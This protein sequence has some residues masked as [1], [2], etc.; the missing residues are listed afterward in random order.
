MVLP[1]DA[2]HFSRQITAELNDGDLISVNDH[3]DDAFIYAHVPQRNL[4]VQYGPYQSSSA[5]NALIYNLVFYALLAAAISLG[6]LPL[7]REMYRLKKAAEHFTH[8]GDLSKLI[9]DK[10]NFFKPVSTALSSMNSK[11][12][13]LIALQKE[14]SDI[15]SHEVR[16]PLARIRFAKE[17]LTSESV[18]FFKHEVEKDIEEIEQLVAEHLTFSRLEHDQPTL[19]LIV[20]SPLTLL[21][22]HV[23]QF[24]SF[25]RIKVILVDNTD[26]QARFAFDEKKFSRAIKNLI[27]NACKYATQQVQ[28]SILRN[29]DDVVI[30]V[31]DD[32]QGITTNDVEEL[33]LPYT[34][35]SN[36]T[37]EGFGLGLAITKK[38]VTWHNGEISVGKSQL[39]GGASF[40]LR[41]PISSK[42]I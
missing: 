11:I 6:L 42:S 31:E 34:R 27:D 8:T 37:A 7:F 24:D 3:N 23:H 29:D 20:D 28:V 9:V 1:D 26:E 36:N 32:G 30:S 41:F 39:L 13:R 4:I 35:L 10:A 33:F 40:E 2:I 21:R 5:N 25:T 18:A 14:L 12:A 15:L 38:I 19:E 16:T 17:A 22:Q